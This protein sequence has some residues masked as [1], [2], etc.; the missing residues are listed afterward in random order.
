MTRRFW[1][2]LYDKKNDKLIIYSLDTT[3]DKIA[4][5]KREQM[6]TIPEEYRILTAKTNDKKYLE[7]SGEDIAYSELEYSKVDIINGMDYH[8]LR[9]SE[10]LEDIKKMILDVYYKR[11]GTVGRLKRITFNEFSNIEYLL[12]INERYQSEI[13]DYKNAAM[14]DIINI[15]R[16]LFVYERFVRENLLGVT[17]EELRQILDL[18]TLSPPLETIDLNEVYKLDSYKVTQSTGIQVLNK[19]ETSKKIL[20]LITK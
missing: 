7:S 8:I 20:S 16:L 4:N 14:N 9:A 13:Y 11:L 17:D 3:I 12:L 15:P 19:I 2:N 1:M 5:F 10:Q 6:L 18:Y